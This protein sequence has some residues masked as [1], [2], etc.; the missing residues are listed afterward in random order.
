ML[1]VRTFAGFSVRALFWVLWWLIPEP[2]A[3]SFILL[4]S[5]TEGY[6]Y[7]KPAKF[8]HKHRTR[9]S[10]Q[11]QRWNIFGKSWGALFCWSKHRF[12]PG[13]RCTTRWKFPEKHSGQR[14]NSIWIQ[15]RQRK[16]STCRLTF[17]SSVREWI[18]VGPYTVLKLSFAPIPLHSTPVT[19]NTP[20]SWARKVF[21]QFCFAIVPKVIWSPLLWLRWHP[22][23]TQIRLYGYMNWQRCVCAR[24]MFCEKRLTLQQWNTYVW[25]RLHQ[26]CPWFQWVG[27][28]SCWK[29]SHAPR[30]VVSTS[31][32][33]V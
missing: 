27:I 8:K 29:Q 25:L 12:S 17:V 23:D 14:L 33:T 15:E 3:L 19:L 30:S 22:R 10:C 11:R 21:E 32:A 24:G 2:D 9:K 5:E 16:D 31:Q 7:W 18:M 4:S 26:N 28:F 13:S 1:A 6:R 20:S